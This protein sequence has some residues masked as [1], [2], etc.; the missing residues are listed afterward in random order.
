[1]GRNP[2]KNFTNGQLI[3]AARYFRALG[4]VSRLRII[5]ALNSGER[6][7]SD[8][9]NLTGLSQPNASRHLGILIAANLIEKRKDG[10]KVLYRVADESLTEVCALAFGRSPNGR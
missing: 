8:L 2:L 9:V 3:G 4:E 6:S 10:V 5:Q 1:M 7:V